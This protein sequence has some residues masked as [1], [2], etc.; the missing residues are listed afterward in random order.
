MEAAV[1]TILCNSRAGKECS[2][3]IAV[4]CGGVE[5]AF[6]R[7]TQRLVAVGWF[8]ARSQG[9]ARGLG[10]PLPQTGDGEINRRP[11]STMFAAYKGFKRLLGTTEAVVRV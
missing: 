8:V 2:R 10:S 9:C 3:V 6:A 1:S 5:V 11:C 4:L 7:A